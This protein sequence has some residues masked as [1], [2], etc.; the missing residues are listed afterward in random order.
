MIIVKPNLKQL[1]QEKGITQQ[2]L[3]DMTGI[4]Q[5]TLSR[6]DRNTRHE[7]AHLFTISRALGVD[8]VDLFTEQEQEEK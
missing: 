3:S 8:I 7:S 5:G 2:Q 6:F 1:L 4:P